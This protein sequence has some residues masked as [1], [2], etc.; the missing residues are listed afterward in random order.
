MS[1]VKIGSKHARSS[2]FYAVWLLRKT[3]QEASSSEVNTCSNIFSNILC[4]CHHKA[5]PFKT[6]LLVKATSNY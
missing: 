3:N 1:E 2:N 5:V 6:I 4:L